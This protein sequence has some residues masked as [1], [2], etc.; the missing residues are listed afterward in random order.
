MTTEQLKCPKCSAKFKVQKDLD[1][2]IKKA[3]PMK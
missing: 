2:H 3:H 1:D